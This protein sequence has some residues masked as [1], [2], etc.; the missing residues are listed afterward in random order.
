MGSSL[1]TIDCKNCG[2]YGWVDDDYKDGLRKTDCE[3]C[4]YYLEE[5]YIVETGEVTKI[6]EKGLGSEK[7]EKSK[8]D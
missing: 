8:Y 3:H 2:G 4:D 1:S 6:I 7:R 5:E